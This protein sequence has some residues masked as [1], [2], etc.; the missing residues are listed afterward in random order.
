VAE[1][2][3]PPANHAI[4]EHQ[5]GLVLQSVPYAALGCPAG[6]VLQDVLYVMLENTVLLWVECVLTVLLENLVIRVL[7]YASPARLAQLVHT[8]PFHVTPPATLVVLHVLLGNIPLLWVLLYVH[9]V[10]L[11]LTPLLLQSLA[12]Y[13]VQQVHTPQCLDCHH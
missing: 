2:Q 5:A 12:A 6:L 3:Y 7:N 11:E 8:S 9:H 13:C 10:L 4:L 1:L